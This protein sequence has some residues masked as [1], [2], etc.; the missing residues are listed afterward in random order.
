MAIRNDLLRDILS[1]IGGGGSVQWGSV[2]GDIGDQ[3]DLQAQFE[4]ITLD[5]MLVINS[6]SDFDIQ[7]ATTITLNPGTLYQLGSDI[8][9]AKRF[10]TQGSS[11]EGLGSATTLT[12][13]GSGSM[14]TNTN[15]RFAI[16]NIVISC[17]LASVFECIGDDTGN[18]DH[19]IN[20]TS[21]QVSDCVSLLTS[22]GAGAQVFDLVQVTSSSG[23]SVL[24]FTGSTP[25]IVFGFS[26]IGLLGLA[27]GAVGF[28]FG[29]V[30]TQEIEIN[31]VVTFG[32]ATATAISGLSNSGNISTGNLAMVRG[33]NFSAL[34]TPLVN[35]LPTDVRWEF[36]SNAGVP[37]SISD[38]LIFTS[39]NALETTIDTQSVAVKANAIFTYDD[40]SRFTSDGL[41][42]LTYIGERSIRL[43][44]DITATVLAA[45][46]GDKQVGVCVA[47]N[48]VAISATCVS[49]TAS[50][51]K[52]A[53]IST[54][55][56]YS[57]EPSDY[58]EVFVIN[59]TN[60]VNLIVS[61]SVLRV[62]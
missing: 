32:D 19:R 17:A 50:N 49:G 4:S 6:E 59:D 38:G 5:N 23:S 60:T 20:A 42:R 25:A 1:A 39:A 12:Y 26:R 35:V 14:F 18:P 10:I 28:D 34:T 62:N 16:N 43:P 40:L 21:I 29:A 2:G 15:G 8:T 47:I 56:Q 11:L 30:A 36:E 55:W 37:D 57:F 61:Q 41:G 48:G 46:G 33:C 27:A 9:T 52:A 53:A 22:T 31:N 45:S 24:S 58:V 54:I 7:D 44:I 51:T 13:T 3:A